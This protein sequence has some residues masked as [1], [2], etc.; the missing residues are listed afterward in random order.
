MLFPASN[1]LWVINP[2]KISWSYTA[3]HFFFEAEASFNHSCLDQCVS[4]VGMFIG[5][6][7]WKTG[8]FGPAGA[9]PS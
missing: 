4:M 1:G 9:R 7:C 2:R 8:M 6:R 3:R 5:Y